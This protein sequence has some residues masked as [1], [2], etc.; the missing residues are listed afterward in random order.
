MKA[1][2]AMQSGQRRVRAMAGSRF[3][4][5]FWLLTMVLPGAVWLLLL[6]YLPM[7]GVA[8]EAYAVGNAVPE[9]KAAATGVIGSNVELGVARFL[10]TRAEA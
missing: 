8:D 10:R 1:A 5:N 9:A 2:P 4:K 6:R 7:F 3:K